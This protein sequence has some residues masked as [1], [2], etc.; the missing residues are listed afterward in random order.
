M[1]RKDIPYIVA[2]ICQSFYDDYPRKMAGIRHKSRNEFPVPPIAALFN[3]SYTRIPM[4]GFTIRPIDQRPP[5][6]GDAA[7]TTVRTNRSESGRTARSLKGGFSALVKFPGWILQKKRQHGWRMFLL[8]SLSAFFS[9]LVL[10]ALFLW[11]TL[12]SIDEQSILSASQSTVIT[13][14]N[15]IELYRVFGEEDRTIVPDE[16]IPQSLKNAI[17]AIEDK[18]YFERGCID[19][20][21]LARAVFSL[22]NSGG[23]STITRQFA[24]NA[25][26]LKGD[27]II[28]RKLKEFV[29]G[30]SLES[31]YSKKDLLAL[32]LNWIPFGQNAYGVQQASSRYF[33]KDAKDLTLAQSAVLAS[34]P[35]LP[36]YYS[37]YG[38]HVHTSV[39]DTVKKEIL[40]GS[41][42]STN[43]LSDDDVTIGL[44]GV[45]IGSGSTALTTDDSA[46]SGSGHSLY[47]GGRADQ[48]LRSM[49]DAGF[50]TDDER[51]KAVEELTALTFKQVRESIR[52]PH[53]VL[54]VKDQIETLIGSSDDRGVLEQGGITIQTTLDWRLQEAAEQVIAAHKDDVEKRFL[55]DNIALVAL[56]PATRE[57]LAYVGNTDYSADTSEGKIDMA[58]VPRQPGSSFKPFVYASAFQ[59]G[60]GPGT[61]IYDVPTK[62]GDYAPQNFEGSFW[63]LLSARRALGGSRNIPAVKAYFLGGQENEILDLAEKMGVTTPKTAQTD[64]G[65]GAALAIGAAEVP[66]IEMVQ[67]YATFAA[68]GYMKP[69]TGIL[70]V[71]DQRGALL[72]AVDEGA[73]DAQGDQVLDPRIAYEITSILSDVN[74]RPN[75]YW[76]SVLS[77]P[78]TAAAAKTG[79]SN[80]CLEWDEKKINC[81]KRKP[82]NTWTMGFTPALVTGVWV[83]NATNEPLSDKADG[84]TTAAPIWKDFMAKAQKIL[85]PSV[86]VFT[87]PEGLVQAQISLLSGELATECTP[88]AL[89][90]SDIFLAENAPTKDD[91]GCTTL[92]VDKVTGLLASDSCPLE[93]QEQRSFLVPYNASRG[94]FPQWDTD[95][96]KWAQAQAMENPRA[97]SGM[98]LF[99]SG[100][101]G[102]LP[103][104]L[105]P[106]EKCDISLTPGR[107][108]KPT[109]SILSPPQNGTASYPSFLPKLQYT[110]GSKVL[111]IEYTIDGKPMATVTSAPFTPPLRVPKSVDKD[112]THTFRVIVTDQ[113]YNT[114]SAESSITFSTDKSGPD[115]RLTTPEGG[116]EIPA[117]TPL[118]IHAESGDPEGEV[119]YV[120]FYLDT[121]LLSR[122]ASVPY[123]LSYTAKIEPG[124]HS[125]RAVA[126]DLAGNSAED[127]VMI[128]VK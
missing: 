81:K 114:A 29:L 75:E 33:G 80:K 100:S 110:V 85:K 92:T 47:I 128:T 70:K 117:G 66:L 97:G 121:L 90:R 37:P 52:A 89:R 23:A 40:D 78:G 30:C 86:T 3:R 96:M 24:R 49:Q 17:I 61:V 1:R 10:Y 125:V 84:L 77:V 101:G 50:I 60:Y 74:A 6:N 44:L 91:P 109:L 5:R 105:A 107:M 79:T 55:A 36:S 124:Q 83:G 122:D 54:W 14:R 93:A 15:G 26:N 56:E 41:I 111:S 8:Y 76:K 72:E 18:R 20:R 22:G 59:N 2:E 123:E 19:I 34:L 16:Q 9:L 28:N 38:R 11:A 25:L 65:Y 12:P 31:R 73:A 63:G 45:T 67:G 43:E 82:D 68:E 21:A 88:V 126:T 95:V 116:T 48:V 115:I 113:Y 120:E 106:T 57:I 51:K 98:N 127:E 58:Q 112:G 94:D 103:L 35:Q 4:N 39:T 53:F 13:D 118:N 69:I 62:F 7:R 46:V 108:T 64:V 42:T 87:M 71:T 104:P 27:N 99:L 32:Y 102:V 119:K